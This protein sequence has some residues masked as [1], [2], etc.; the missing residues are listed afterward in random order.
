MNIFSHLFVLL[1]INFIIYLCNRGLIRM[2]IDYCLNTSAR[3]KRRK[4]QAFKEWFFYSRFRDV[5]PNIMLIWYFGSM[6]FVLV[7]V[8]AVIIMGIINFGHD[9][10]MFF[11]IHVNFIMF[12]PGFITSIMFKKFRKPGG[13]DVS[14]WIERKG[15][16]KK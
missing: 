10:A 6:I 9:K 4:G 14:R 13:D 1:S 11:C 5:I 12:L 16:N 2:V 3:K 7:A 15:R 8:I